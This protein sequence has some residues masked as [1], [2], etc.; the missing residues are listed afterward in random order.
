MKSNNFR[1]CLI[2]LL[3]TWTAAAPLRQN[4]FS[5][6]K[7]K[8]LVSLKTTTIRLKRCPCSISPQV[9][10]VLVVLVHCYK[11]TGEAHD[12]WRAVSISQ[13][14]ID[15]KLCFCSTHLCNHPEGELF[16]SGSTHPTAAN[17]LATSLSL[18]P[19]LLIIQLVD[20]IR[21]TWTLRSK[22]LESFLPMHNFCRSFWIIWNLNLVFWLF[23]QI[24]IHLL[25]NSQ[26][27][28]YKIVGV[29]NG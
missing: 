16:T 15:V 8:C 18:L 25:G 13:I 7:F 3:N 19:S 5:F 23:W 4:Q 24:K 11:K 29:I 20:F 9:H 26:K 10:S 2:E 27:T 21:F 17:I 14:K 22:W 1:V 6:I 12:Y 28:T